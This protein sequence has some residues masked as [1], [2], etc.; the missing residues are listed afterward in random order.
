MQRRFVNKCFLF[1][2]GSVCLIKRF[3]TGSRNVANISL[4][5]KRL[6]HQSKDLYVMG[7]DALVKL[8]DRYINVAGGY[9][10]K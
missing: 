3:I 7:F 4:M 1:T 6:R 8:W 5:T 2:L 10:E 9:V